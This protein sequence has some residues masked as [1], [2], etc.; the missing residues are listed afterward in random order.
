MHA[1]TCVCVTVCCCR[2]YCKECITA[3]RRSLNVRRFIVALTRGGPN[4]IP[5]PIEMHAHDPVR[6]C[7]DMLAW[8]HQAIATDTEFFRVLFDGDMEYAASSLSP[9]LPSQE[10]TAAKTTVDVDGNEDGATS[11]CTSMV[12]RAFDGVARPLQVRIEQTLASQHG[13]VI[14]YKLVHLLAFY[15]HTFDR[16]V[17]RSLVAVA[18]SHCRGTANG[19]FLR[20]LQMVVDSIAASAQDYST[21]LS[22]THATMD[23]SQRLVALLE[24]SQS[25]LLPEEEKEADLSPLFDGLLPALGQLCDRSVQGLDAVDALVFRINNFSCL[26]IPLKRFPETAKW[27]Q[28]VERDLELWLRDVSELLA[29][30]VLDRCN[31]SS[32]LRHIQRFQTESAPLGES[33]PWQLQGLDGETISTVMEDFCGAVVSLSFPQVDQIAQ[34]D[35]SDKARQLTASKLAAT[36]A[37]VYEFVHDGQH[38]YHASH[39]AASQAQAVLGGTHVLLHH[40]PDDVRTMLELDAA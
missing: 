19:A 12:G 27:L 16:L 38:G 32:L 22:A 10:D 7:G 23:V 21:N 11:G 33:S 31:V 17:A 29:T 3:S 40:T 13:L 36:Y 28:Q 25:S 9:P 8:V 18:L 2:S 1:L 39:A 35:L 24:V 37:F 14:A 26:H 30:R 6:Y 5:R 4:G 34:P 15:H 20:Q